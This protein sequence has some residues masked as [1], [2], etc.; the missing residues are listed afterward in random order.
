[1]LYK[2]TLVQL[3]ISQCE[4]IWD[5]K[6]FTLCFIVA[7]LRSNSGNCKHHFKGVNDALIWKWC[8]QGSGFTF[9]PSFLNII[10]RFPRGRRSLSFHKT[11]T[12]IVNNGRLFLLEDTWNVDVRVNLQLSH[13]ATS[14]SILLSTLACDSA[15]LIKNMNHDHALRPRP[16][17]S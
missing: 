4:L 14:E 5:Q 12:A 9:V 8:S 6:T 2:T 10:L 16:S 13:T 3:Y 17:S 7:N 15:V 11:F 1:M